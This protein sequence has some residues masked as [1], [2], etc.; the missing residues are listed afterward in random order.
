M[1]LRQRIRH[2]LTPEAHGVAHASFVGYG[3]A[4]LG[5]SAPLS[6]GFLL[7]GGLLLL[8]R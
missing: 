1:A 8:P 3:G 2:Y 5:S 6:S 4:M 7:G